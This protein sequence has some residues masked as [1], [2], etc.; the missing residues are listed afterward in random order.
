MKPVKY[1]VV[2]RDSEGLKVLTRPDTI[3]R[4]SNM[5]KKMTAI[6]IENLRVEAN[7][8]EF[9]K[10][11]REEKKRSAAMRANLKK[12]L[13]AARKEVA[14]EQKVLEKE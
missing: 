10:I 5:F 13:Q 4:A 7:S 2:K 1:V 8:K 11:L 6:G 9:R 12:A 14:E 3:T